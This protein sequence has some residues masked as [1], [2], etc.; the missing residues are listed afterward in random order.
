MADDRAMSDVVRVSPADLRPLD[1]GLS[2]EVLDW[3][4]ELRMV[5]DGAGLSIN[6]FARL[7]HCFVDKGTI[8]RYLN[9]RRVPRD[10]WFLDKVLAIRAG[11]GEPVTPAVREHMR[12]LQLRALQVAHPH[13]YRVRLISDELEIALTGKQEAERYAR[14]LEEQLVER[15]RQIDE[16]SE[17]KDRLRVAWDADRVAMQ[18]DFDQLTREIDEIAGQLRLAHKRAA[19]AEQRCDLLEGL[20]DHL[21]AHSSADDE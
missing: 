8:S 20:L 2:A 14:A 6:R 4:S 1:P 12:G 5:W 19:R 21:D 17:D 10:H 7:N 16:L 18:A 3:V 13:E 11:N 9:G 15:T